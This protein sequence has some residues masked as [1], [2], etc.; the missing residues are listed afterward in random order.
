MYL[1]LKIREN[2]SAS[3]VERFQPGCSHLFAM[4]KASTS[5]DTM[6]TAVTDATRSLTPTR[7]CR[8]T[9]RN[10]HLSLALRTSKTLL[11]FLS[12]ALIEQGKHSA[13]KPPKLNIPKISDGAQSQTNNAMQYKPKPCDTMQYNAIQ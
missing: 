6:S 12:D 2:S 3:S 5:Q 9:R 11:G 4:W 8:L 10:V 1:V 13:S 7:N